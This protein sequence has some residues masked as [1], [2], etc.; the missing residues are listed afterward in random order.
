MT[1]VDKILR[2]IVHFI[3][4]LAVVFFLNIEVRVANV[5]NTVLAKEHFLKHF[6][7]HIDSVEVDGHKISIKMEVQ[8]NIVLSNTNFTSKTKNIVLFYREFRPLKRT[9][10]PN[11]N[12]LL[13]NTYLLTPNHSVLETFRL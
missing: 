1:L 3:L 10:L 7:G 4:V 13:K 12:G 6:Q 9:K 5:V 11:S 8:S 2:Y